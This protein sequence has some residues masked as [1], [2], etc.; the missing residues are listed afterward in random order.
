MDATAGIVDADEHSGVG[1][2]ATRVTAGAAGVLVLVLLVL[3][4]YEAP[5]RA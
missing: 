3:K 1:E 5:Q 2:F 4:W